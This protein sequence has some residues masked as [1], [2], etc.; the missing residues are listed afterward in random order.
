MDALDPE[1]LAAD[2]VALGGRGRCWIAYSGGLDST[3]LLHALTR[4]PL[5]R[6][7]GAIHID[8]GLQPVARDWR[9]H[10]RERCR[11]LGVRF[12]A[13]A[14][15]LSPPPGESLEAHAREARY[16]AFAALLDDD[17]LLLTA[18][19]L[20]DQAE[21]LLLALLRGSGVHGLAAMPGCAPLGRGRLVRPLLG[22]SRAQLL[23]YARRH[24]LDWIEDPSN[25]ALHHDRNLLRHQVLPL[26]RGRWPAAAS[27][28][29]RSAAHC[30]EAA[31]LID[32]Q[33]GR[34][35]AAVAG[36]VPGT[37]SVAGLCGLEPSVRRAVARLWLRRQGFAVPG[38][39][40]L[41][42][43]VGE[44]LT[45]RADAAPQVAWTGCEVRRYRDD[46]YALQPLPRPPD[47]ALRWVSGRELVLPQGLGELRLA[48][49]ELA[50]EVRFAGA[51][52]RCRQRPG[53]PLRALKKVF[54]EAGVAPWLRPLVPLLFV[55][56]TDRL[57]AVAG[58]CGCHPE[59]TGAPGRLR[60][61]GHP[62]G[63]LGVFR[64]VCEIGHAAGGEGAQ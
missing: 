17:E 55:A 22:V 33:A 19:H 58:V 36:A 25:D 30:A 56:G 54:Q 52:G 1:R 6:P 47:A 20:D 43:V 23:D 5:A 46:L 15:A 63:A 3:V 27:T 28:I 49:V 44:L 14:L 16:R 53:G 18:H 31:T 12:V 10:C 13:R 48:G 64:E 7:L 29:A 8:H 35:L 61:S 42:R 37:L 39:A 51:G 45:A 57:V 2:L 41:E 38:R 26:L 9:R 62:W 34:D 24:R 21:T 4:A 11:V 40:R 59:E 32:R 60:W 50:L